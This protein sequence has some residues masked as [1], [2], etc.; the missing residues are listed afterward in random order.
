M[1]IVQRARRAIG[2]LRGVP[3]L[4]TKSAPYV[5]NYVKDAPVWHLL[6]FLTYAREGFKRNALIYSA[7][8]YKVRAVARTRLRPYT[9]ERDEREL[10]RDG[11]PL[12]E[13]LRR[14]NEHQS[15]LEFE[16]QLIVYLNLSGN[17]YVY[18]D[19]DGGGGIVGLYPLRPDR[20]LIV[21]GE[22]DIRGY[23]YIPMG[24]TKDNGVPLVKEDVMHVKFPNPDDDF[25]GMGY[26]LSPLSAS[27]S[28]GDI[29]NDITKFLKLFMERGAV[30]PGVLKFE[31]LMDQDQVDEARVRWRERYG[32]VDNWA[33]VAVLDQ[34]GSYQQLSMNFKDMGFDVL[35]ERTEA[36][37]LG[38]FGVPAILLDTRIAMRN[39]TY[40]N[41]QEARRAFWED[42]M[43][44]EL[45]LFDEEY[46]HYLNDDVVWVERDYSKVPALQKNIPELVT[47]AV[48]LW[49]TGV[50]IDQ[51]AQTVGLPL[52]EVPAL[53]RPANILLMGNVDEP[54]VESPKM[55][56]P[57]QRKSRWTDEQK[58][59]IW[60]K[61]DQISRNWEGRFGEAA[62]AAFERD[63]REI[64][65]IVQGAGEKALRRK[66]TIDWLSISSE[67]TAYL[68]ESAPGGWRNTFVP[69]MS[70]LVRDTGDYWSSEL[71]LAWDVR[72]LLGEAWFA[73]YTLVFS[74]P[75]NETTSNAIQGILGQAQSEGWSI[76]Q[77]E[78]RLGQVFQQWMT[79]DLSGQDFAWLEER[80]PPWRREL[81]ARTETTRLQAAG[82]RALYAEWGLERKEWLSTP[83][84]RT[85]P[86]HVAANGQ[87]RGIDEP[88]EVGGF[89][90][91]Q[92]GD[93]TLGAPIREAGNCR[94]TVL[95]V[96]D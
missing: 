85:R 67:I 16:G 68:T 74:Q 56:P 71:G 91:M 77:M 51:A 15:W 83:D 48:N 52:N 17:A 36:R 25:E 49:S 22:R 70:G 27:A 46:A 40:A 38:P 5:W 72:N 89:E 13:L 43:M 76:Y 61:Q 54:E 41:K 1:G 58:A 79:G 30:P 65:V 2:R 6:D 81:I 37:I 45:S 29:D 73:E 80:M 20:V 57:P 92:P 93:M 62:E 32:G 14:P 42:T 50:P 18:I 63:R 24:L 21:P 53:Y 59:L 3:R 78:Q 55:L 31:T 87:V 75:I 94:C 10:V 69:V 44:Y 82:S 96:V 35:D 9:G 23:L 28:A 26:G 60:Q 19:R 88:F 4:L 86:T 33:D 12:A 11:H 84:E 66:A 90:M 7:I 95:P 34:G 47:A 64:M 8:M 39:S